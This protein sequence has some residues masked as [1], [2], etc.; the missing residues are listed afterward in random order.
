M[1]CPIA[2]LRVLSTLF[3]YLLLPYLLGPS[4]FSHQI[5]LLSKAHSCLT[6]LELEAD[7]RNSHLAWQWLR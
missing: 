6:L 1:L 7:P 5:D 4:F 3:P 2:G